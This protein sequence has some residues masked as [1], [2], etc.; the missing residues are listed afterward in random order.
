MRLRIRNKLRGKAGESIGET[1]VALLISALALVMLAGAITASA[2]MIKQSEGALADYYSALNDVAD[3]KTAGEDGSAITV[4]IKE[5]EASTTIKL[6]DT[7]RTYLY[8]RY[9]AFAGTPIVSYWVAPTS[10]SGG[11]QP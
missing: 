3:H 7:D 4:T 8:S 5:K 9:E 6:F 2:R 1:L 10:T 11:G